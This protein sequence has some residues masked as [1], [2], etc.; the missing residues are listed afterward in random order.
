M[1]KPFIAKHKHVFTPIAPEVD[2]FN[3]VYPCVWNWCIRCGCLK[4]NKEIFKPG[5]KQNKVLIS[6]K[7]FEKRLFKQMSK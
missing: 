1:N 4:L 6:E 7:E 3:H 5:G 2:S